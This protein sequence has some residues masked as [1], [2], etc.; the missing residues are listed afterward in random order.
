MTSIKLRITGLA[1]LALVL[2]L[3][4]LPFSVAAQDLVDPEDRGV[5]VVAGPH[6]VRAVLINTN[7][8]AG[9]VQMALFIT[10]ANTG[11]VVSDA[12][13]VIKAENVKEEYEGWATA[14]NSPNMPERYDLRLNLGS[15]G[16]WVI[17]VDVTSHLG[18]GGAIA[19]TLVV[20]S[21]NR[22]TQGSLVFFGVFA[23]M[24]LGLFYI[25]WSTRRNNRRRR[26]ATQG[27]AQG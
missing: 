24:M 17:N 8:A 13:V 18:H 7:M 11:E 12:R 21:L 9:F 6:S 16:E 10:D 26:E 22:Y 19:M 4:V 1:M 5:V 27:E 25:I 2:I 20:P 3:I 15:T 14:H 23:A